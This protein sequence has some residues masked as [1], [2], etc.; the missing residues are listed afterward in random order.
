MH[1]NSGQFGISEGRLGLV[2]P[3]EWIW[4]RKLSDPALD[5]VAHWHSE[6][7]YGPK[8]A[9]LARA[10]RL[11]MNARIDRRY[12]AERLR[13]EREHAEWVSDLKRRGHY[14]RSYQ[15]RKLPK[16]R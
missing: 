6:Y 8:K 2:K 13:Q 15:P 5:D 3:D 10:A 9:A 14:K 7:V 4:L 1:A 12:A 16:L 11:V